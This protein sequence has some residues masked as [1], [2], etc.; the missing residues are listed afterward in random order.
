MD[1]HLQPP[2][3]PTPPSWV[4]TLAGT[5]VPFIL[6]VEAGVIV[7]FCLLTLSFSR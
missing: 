2:L 6:M 4:T 1:I 7:P 5:I 3:S